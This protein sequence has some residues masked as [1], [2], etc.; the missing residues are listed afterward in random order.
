MSLYQVKLRKDIT[1]LNNI[2]ILRY[3]S[4]VCTMSHFDDVCDEV[5]VIDAVK[6]GL[7]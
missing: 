2:Y 5:T 6:Q 7:Q 3:A 4:N 1:E